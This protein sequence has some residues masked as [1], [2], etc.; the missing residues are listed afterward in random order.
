MIVLVTGGRDYDRPETVFAVLDEIDKLDHIDNVIHGAARGVDTF[1]AQWAQARGRKHSPHEVSAET[2][3]ALG[4]S[5]GPA[6]NAAMLQ[7]AVAAGV[8]VCVGFPGGGGTRDMLRRAFFGGV[9][10]LVV[11]D[12]KAGRYK[13]APVDENDF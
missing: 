12:Q 13:I 8:G 11:T 2:W 7:A 1:A 5:A 9:R 3:A 10:T 6:R 4:L